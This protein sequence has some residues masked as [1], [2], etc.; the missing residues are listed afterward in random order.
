LSVSILHEE[1]GDMAKRAARKAKKKT[2]AKKSRKLTLK[3]KVHTDLTPRA[4]TA[5]SVKA[6][7]VFKAGYVY[8]PAAITPAAITNV[9]TRPQF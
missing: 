4:G 8:R 5:K 3:K 2:V 7:Y 1:A 9:Q 6:G